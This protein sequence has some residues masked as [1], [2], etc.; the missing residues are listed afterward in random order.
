MVR[1]MTRLQEIKLIAECSERNRL[2]TQKH[3]DAQRLR[4]DT[5]EAELKREKEFHAVNVT[6]S[7][8]MLAAAEQRIAEL[9]DLLRR[10]GVDSALWL[11][12]FGEP[13][14]GSYRAAFTEIDAAPNQKS[15]GESQ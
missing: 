4:A 5:A 13:S 7:E 10:V 9:S 3:F 2:E 15:E 8:R 14:D 6:E 12:E 1:V 11:S